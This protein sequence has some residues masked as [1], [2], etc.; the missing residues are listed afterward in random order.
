M[1]ENISIN[2]HPFLSSI[3]SI[4]SALENDAIRIF[5]LNILTYSIVI[6]FRFNIWDLYVV[7]RGGDDEKRKTPTNE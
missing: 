7:V 5:K 4:D 6:Y 2:T 3:A 1:I